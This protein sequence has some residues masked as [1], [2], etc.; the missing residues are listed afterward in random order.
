MMRTIS[1]YERE[2]MLEDE[3][4]VIYTGHLVLNGAVVAQAV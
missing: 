2:T 4:T 1:L 3:D